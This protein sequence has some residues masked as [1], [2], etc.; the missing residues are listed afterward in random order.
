MPW[1]SHVASPFTTWPAQ[2]PGRQT[3]PLGQSR[4]APTPSHLPSYPQ[5]DGATAAHDPAV[6]G[7]APAASGTHLLS[8][9]A[10]AQV[11]HP[12]AQAVSQQTPSTQKPLVHSMGLVQALP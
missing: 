10:A 5:L 9:A 8:E 12:D 7:A 11:W 2:V 6:R 3:V 1:P 4:Q